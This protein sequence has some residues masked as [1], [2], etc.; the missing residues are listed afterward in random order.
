M[1]LT[2]AENYSTVEW[3]ASVAVCTIKEFY[4]YLYGFPFE[5]IT[6]YNP[7]TSL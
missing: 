5:L 3:E 4:A 7:S 1:Q 6:D 2:K